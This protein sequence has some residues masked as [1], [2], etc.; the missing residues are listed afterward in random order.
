MAKPWIRTTL[1]AAAVAT[2]LF[3]IGCGGGASSNVLP[4]TP[5]NTSAAN[6]GTVPLSVSDAASEDW[7]TIGAKILAVSLTP[8]AGGAP[9][10]V[11]T[12]PTPVPVTNLVDLD[13][14]AEI[15]AFP[16]SVP[17]GAYSGATLTLSANPGD[18][19]LVVANDPEAGFAGTPGAA[20]PAAQI[21]IQGASGSAGNRTVT[22]PVRFASTLTVNAGQ[23]A[24][25][26]LEF[27]LAHPAFIVDHV[28]ALG[29]FWAVNFRAAL[30]HHP[31][32]DVARLV[33]RHHYGT[34][35]SVAAGGASL[36]LDKACPV[37]PAT[38]PETAIS[39]TL[40]FTVQADATNG[41][42]YYD[43]DAKA[44][45]TVLR[46]FSSLASSLAGKYVRVAA[47]YQQ[48]GSL[49]AVRLWAS[50]SF[51]SVWVSPEGHVLHVDTRNAAAPVVTIESADA[52][53]VPLTVTSATQI[54]FRAPATP[55]ADTAPITTDPVGFVNAGNLVRGFKVHA[56][57][58]D[59]LATPLVAQ[60]L[61]I[62]IAKYD[63]RI[64]NPTS[65][66]FTYTRAFRDAGDDYS[67]TLATIAGT[68]VNGKNATGTA[69]DGFQWWNFA[70]P[71]QADTGTGAIAD[72]VAATGGSVN[73]YA[74]PTQALR[75]WGVSYCRWN[76]TA[77]PDDWAANWAVLL[78]VPVPLGNVATAWNAG[79]SSFGMSIPAGA[80]TVAV[81][82]GSAAQAAT[83]AYQVDRSNGVVTVSPQDL[84]TTA[85]MNA[86][87]AA[88]GTTGTWVKV[89]GIP[90]ANG[91][92]KA[93]VLF[94]YTGDAPAA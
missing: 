49:V 56:S 76:D 75:P 33:L 4:V 11:Y 88:L 66:A 12:A 94:Y 85:G 15:L 74:D 42:L 80:N 9:V 90:E 37:Y 51:N 41:T 32:Y 26:D 5:N 21:Q 72:F 27:D 81:D 53:G 57:V 61:D 3:I 45:A 92:L 79:T 69:V 65:T 22:V 46:D 89:F 78:P 43:V 86:V 6:A 31:V 10:A 36:T 58:V 24:P 50:S 23:S 67:K 18:V 64:S 77:A 55:A 59:P 87:S 14:L 35:Q 7:A 54:F 13:N 34:V 70:Y 16:S 1:G 68:S 52:V 71:A 38:T 91:H 47:R 48:D 30:R 28:T 25:L 82:L 60:S 44:G 39:T 17:A 62:E 63:G 84:T 20:I 2:P 40:P 93:Y 19:S 73:F 83:L 8:A 29:T